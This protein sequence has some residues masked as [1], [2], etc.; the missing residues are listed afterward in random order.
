MIIRCPGKPS[1]GVTSIPLL[2]VPVLSTAGDAGVTTAGSNVIWASYEN[3]PKPVK[4]AVIIGTTIMP[5]VE[6]TA[7]SETGT[8]VK[9]D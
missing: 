4:L 8:P 2:I 5:G 7:G 1:F 6:L 3:T 9:V